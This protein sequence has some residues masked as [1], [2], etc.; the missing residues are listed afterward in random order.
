MCMMIHVYDDND[1]ECVVTE[2]RA[3][4]LVPEVCAILTKLNHRNFFPLTSISGEISYCRIIQLNMKARKY[5]N[6][7]AATLGANENE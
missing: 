5:Q 3:D 6:T 4:R 1:Y 2:Q 7:S